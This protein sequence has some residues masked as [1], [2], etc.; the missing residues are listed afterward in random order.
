ME[1]VN[2]KHTD[3]D[4]DV[5]KKKKSFQTAAMLLKEEGQTRRTREVMKFKMNCEVIMLI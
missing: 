1:H 5:E 2:K 4:I 3:C